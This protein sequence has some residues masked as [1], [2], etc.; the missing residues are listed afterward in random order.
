MVG[1]AYLT[2]TKAVR[3]QTAIIASV[4]FNPLN[5]LR[6]RLRQILPPDARA[7]DLKEHIRPD[8]TT[9]LSVPVFAY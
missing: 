1:E 8:I 6:Y 9:D 2:V 4:S 5:P 3:D 7:F